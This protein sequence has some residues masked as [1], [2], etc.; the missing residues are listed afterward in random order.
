[1]REGVS[2]LDPTDAHIE[3]RRGPEGPKPTSM[4]GSWA[5]ST[6]INGALR[7]RYRLDNFSSKALWERLVRCIVDLN[8]SHWSLWNRYRVLGRRTPAHNFCYHSFVQTRKTVVVHG[9]HAIAYA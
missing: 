2:I 7:Q 5:S 6:R 4:A 9:A 3:Q 1:M 8:C